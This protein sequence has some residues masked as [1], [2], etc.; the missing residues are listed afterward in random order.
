MWPGVMACWMIP[1]DNVKLASLSFCK[2][3]KGYVDA[4]I[5]REDCHRVQTTSPDDEF[6][7][8]WM[9]FLGMK[10]EGILRNYTPEKEDHCMYARVE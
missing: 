10:N 3:I 2:V 6:H 1:S 5:E 9:K 7:A 4:I 8:R